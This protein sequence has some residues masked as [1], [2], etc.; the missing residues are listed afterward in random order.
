MRQN[1]PVRK[2]MSKELITVHKGQKLSEVKAL[3]AERGVHHV[4]VVS[5]E[6]LVG[7]ISSTDMMRI[8]FAS[9]FGQDPRS[10]AAL[11]DATQAITDVMKTDLTTVTPAT[12]IREAAELLSSGR[13]HS[14]PVV[15]D[16][17]LV[18]MVTSTDL[19]RYLLAQY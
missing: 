8:S 10:E 6:A 15:E 13:F 12:P 17:N 9:A 5:G 19:I 1:E 4:P 14:V 16:G 2:I 11:L 7:M 18:D 3:L